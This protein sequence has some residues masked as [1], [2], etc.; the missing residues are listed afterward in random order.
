MIKPPERVAFLLQ[1]FV[2]SA[3]W[4]TANP[5]WQVAIPPKNH[6][7]PVFLVAIP[8]LQTRNRVFLIENPVFYTAIAV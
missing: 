6:R 7:N 3:V 2:H 8:L 5:V 4:E 1:A